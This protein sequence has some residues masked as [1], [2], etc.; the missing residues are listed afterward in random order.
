MPELL[1]LI[2]IEASQ[3]K[4]K[5]LEAKKQNILAPKPPRKTKKQKIQEILFQDVIIYQLFTC[6][7][8][9]CG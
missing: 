8:W 9:F 7:F 3:E 4:I 1:S 2:K 6:F 5:A